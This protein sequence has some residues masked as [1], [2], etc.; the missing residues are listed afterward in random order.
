[1]PVIMGMLKT[2]AMPFVLVN[3]KNE[4]EHV[5]QNYRITSTSVLGHFGLGC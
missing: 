2:R 1:M 4:S 3:C 5:L